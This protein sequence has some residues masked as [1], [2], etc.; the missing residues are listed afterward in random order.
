[1]TETCSIRSLTFNTN[2]IKFYFSRTEVLS[3]FTVE[4]EV[5]HETAK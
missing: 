5:G 4:L 2:Q 3:L 1:M